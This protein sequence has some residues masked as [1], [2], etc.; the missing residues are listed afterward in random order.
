MVLVPI[1]VGSEAIER[2]IEITIPKVQIEDDKGIPGFE[3]IFG[4]A[5]L[6]AVIYLFN[7]KNHR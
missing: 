5:G 4:I 3:L 7:R 6:L 1:K 2:D